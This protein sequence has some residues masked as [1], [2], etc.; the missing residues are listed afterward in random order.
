MT[1]STSKLLFLGF[2]AGAF[3]VLVF[4]QSAWLML[5]YAGIIPTERPAWPMDPIPPFGVPSLLSKMFW[6]GLWGAG[7]ALLLARIEGAAFWLAWIV[8]G[9]IAPP[10]V[11]FY[12]VPVVKGLPIPEL[13]PRAAASSFVNAVW[14][15]GTAVF[16]RLLGGARRT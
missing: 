12:V 3:S 8:A 9:A 2:V 10:L 13:W 5:N 6:G 4:H 15:L 7:L 16:L 1:T 14:G 11:A